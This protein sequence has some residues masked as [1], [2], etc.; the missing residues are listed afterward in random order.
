MAE[1]SQMP[2]GPWDIRGSQRPLVTPFGNWYRWLWKM[3]KIH[4]FIIFLYFF[5][6]YF[7]GESHPQTPPYNHDSPPNCPRVP[8]Y[9]AVPLDLFAERSLWINT[10]GFK[11]AR[12][13]YWSAQEPVGQAQTALKKPGPTTNTLTGHEELWTSTYSYKKAKTPKQAMTTDRQCKNKA[14]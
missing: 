6:I 1:G 5:H 2:Q 3:H 14:Q 7:E 9:A 13:H 8:E 12:T 11:K 10:C 4:R